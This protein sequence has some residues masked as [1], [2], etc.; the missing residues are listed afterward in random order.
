[1]LILWQSQS[2]WDRLNFDDDKFDQR[3]DHHVVDSVSFEKKQKSM[4]RG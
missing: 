1:M 4:W 2:E 3:Q